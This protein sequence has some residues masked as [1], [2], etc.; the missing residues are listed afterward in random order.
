MY[1]NTITSDITITLGFTL[2]ISRFVYQE[3]ERIGKLNFSR[4]DLIGKG[5]YGWVFKGKY[6]KG[7]IDVAVKRVEKRESQVESLLLSKADS[8]PNIVR[9]FCTKE[10]D[11]EFMYLHYIF[12][13]NFN[14]RLSF[15]QL[16]FIYFM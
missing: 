6:N 4:L 7:M 9:Y 15:N 2:S 13:F 10:N 11:V 1:T 12:K 5:R 3:M 14:V 16:S 8:H